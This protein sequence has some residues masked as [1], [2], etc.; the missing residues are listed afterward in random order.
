MDEAGTPE[1]E[2][3]L[4]HLNDENRQLLKKLRNIVPRG[5]LRLFAFALATAVGFREAVGGVLDCSE[6]PETRLG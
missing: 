4:L 1:R 6:M 5:H 2:R 3:V